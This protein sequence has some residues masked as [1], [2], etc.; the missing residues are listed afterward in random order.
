MQ[1]GDAEPRVEPQHAIRQAER[2]EI[3]EVD[4]RSCR[5]GLL[6]GLAALRVLF[7]DFQALDGIGHVGRKVEEHRRNLVA[8]LSV[9][10][11]APSRNG[12]HGDQ[13]L[14]GKLALLIE[15]AA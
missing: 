13:G 2:D 1:L 12:N 6:E 8:H 5:A 15:I 3:P 9:L 11:I 7:D 14:G 10:V 4:E